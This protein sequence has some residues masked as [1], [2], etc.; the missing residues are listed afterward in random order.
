MSR[1]RKALQKG[2]VLVADGA[3]GTMLQKMGLPPG[4]APER[5][6]LENPDGVRALHKH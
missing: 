2:Q 4:V 3:N 1:F 5:W 6:N